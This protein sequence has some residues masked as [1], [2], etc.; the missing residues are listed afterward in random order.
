M[1]A[2]RP[3]P[4]ARP[5]PCDTCG[6]DPEGLAPG[7]A[8]VAVRSFPRRWRE[9]F[10]A[11]AERDGGEWLL[12]EPAGDGWSPLARAVHVTAALDQAA[13]ALMQVWERERP[14]IAPLDPDEGRTAAPTSGHHDVCARMSRAAERLAR[15]LERYEGADWERAGRRAGVQVTA[16]LLAADAVHEA[17]HHLRA[18]TA[19]LT[20]ALGEPPVEED[21]R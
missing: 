7:D 6:F 8:A 12:Q 5:R 4:L 9:L 17:S 1:S 3:D 19:E 10:D 11:V 15:V 21:A 20:E 18:C 13:D 16:R 2:S 14:E